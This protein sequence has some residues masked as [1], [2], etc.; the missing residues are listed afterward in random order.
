VKLLDAPHGAGETL[1]G[2]R[3][4]RGGFAFGGHVRVVVPDR[5]KFGCAGAFLRSFPSPNAGGAST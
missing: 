4:Q 3:G 5:R 2:E 1:P